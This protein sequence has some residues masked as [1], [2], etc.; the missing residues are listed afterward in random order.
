MSSGSAGFSAALAA[1]GD[2]A[3]LMAMK[4]RIQAAA[5][6]RPGVYRMQS[7]DGEVLYVGKSKRVR[8]RLL[9]YFRASYPDEKGAR[10]VREVSRIEWDYHPSEF[11]A[12]LM[13]MRL[14]KK[15]RPRFNFALKR[16][17]RNYVFIRLTSGIAPRLS[18]VRGGAWEDGGTYYGPY[19]GASRMQDAI[20]ELNDVLLLR[21][22]TLDRRMSYSDQQEL[23]MA[24]DRTPACVRFEI[25]KCLGPCIAAC[26]SRQYGES[27]RR[28]RAFLDGSD[29]APLQYLED[30]MTACSER[31]EYERAASL[32]DK[33]ERLAEL[34]LQFKRLR[35]AT[36]TLSFLY[37]VPGV[38]GDDR[39]YLI[40]RGLVR[41][42]SGLPES[43]SDA[44]QLAE[45][46]ASIY[47]GSARAPGAIPTHEIDELLLLS[48]WFK[49]NPHELGRTRQPADVVPRGL[50]RALR[51]LLS[52]ASGR[53]R[54]DGGSRGASNSSH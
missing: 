10:L 17:D 37:V 41:A 42:E 54:T 2:E 33:K 6:D 38:G 29:N 31:L 28:A 51:K 47:R 5:L 19:F 3:A 27:V 23:F 43:A 22:C 8:S 48:H 45:L 40:R 39:V 15:L 24:V 32:R 53:R 49:Q 16:D 44:R 36:E 12:L 1:P 50:A 21:D 13:E 25:G 7:A 46:A 30:E 34:H 20:R 14:I 18:V 35:F 4:Q 52:A 11:A 9:S 26:T